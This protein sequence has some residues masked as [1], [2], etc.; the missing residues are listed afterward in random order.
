M[1]ENTF[2]VDVVVGN[3]NSLKWCTTKSVASNLFHCDKFHRI[4]S[5]FLCDGYR[6]C[7]NGLD[8]TLS[9]CR[10][11]E[12]VYILPVLSLYV[13][14]FCLALFF[15]SCRKQK[16]SRS[17]SEPAKYNSNPF[18]TRALKDVGDFLKNS[19]EQN[20]EKLENTI[21]KMGSLAK[22]ELLKM[23]YNIEMKGTITSELMM[24]TVVGKV[25][26]TKSKI[27][28]LLTLV[29][30][31]NMP[32]AFKTRVI[33]LINMGGMTKL[34]NSIEEWIP[35]KEL[36]YLKLAF[37]L[38]TSFV[39][40]I[41]LPFQDIKDILT[42]MT[43]VNFN[44]NVIQGRTNLI[45]DVPL[46]TITGFLLGI[47]IA[48]QLLKLLTSSSTDLPIQVPVCY[49]LGFK[50]DPRWIPYFS[51][52]Y[53][54]IRKI[55]QTWKIFSFKLEILQK[56]EDLER[57]EGK[58]ANIWEDIQAK[59]NEVNKVYLKQERENF[60][61][62]KI[63]VASILGDILQGAILLVLILRTDLRLRGSLGLAD[64]ASQLNVDSRESI[65]PGCKSEMTKFILRS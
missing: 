47:F 52:C 4:T 6:D 60:S 20:E 44:L 12:P 18:V 65:M 23:A 2:N 35:S 1:S 3:Q 36:T 10:P 46:N 13:T 39:Q 62:K 40:I 38:V 64:L 43:L 26:V 49:P 7:P 16:I 29:R 63:A 33:D 57:T 19:S 21:K 48:V 27:K 41:S 42:I 58:T 22:V 17:E 5:S 45:D 14:V 54:S 61:T 37:D 59:S 51:Q 15:V 34:K 8:E 30:H 11:Q 56:L 50:C 25:F 31:S 32:T 28:P 24:K 9:M 53:T 55:H